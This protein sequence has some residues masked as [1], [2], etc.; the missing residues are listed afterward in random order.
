MEAQLQHP[1]DTGL[2]TG[3]GQGQVH[4][5]GEH[6]HHKKSVLKK[7]KA[8]AKKIKDTLKHGLGHDHDHD[9]HEHEHRPLQGEHEEEEDETD[10]EEMEEDAEV[11]GGPYAI[12]STD[13]R[14]EDVGPMVNLENPTSPKEDRYDH[15]KMKHEEAHRPVLQRQDEFARP[16]SVG[17]THF[18]EQRH[19]PPH[20]TKGTDHGKVE[21]Q[22]LHVHKI[23][24]QTGLENPHAS[25]FPEERHRSPF[26]ETK[27]I[28]LATAHGKQGHQGLQEH[29]NIGAPTGLEKP[30]SSRFREETHRPH[31][32]ADTHETKDI[33]YVTAHAKLEDQGLVGHKIGVP[34]GIEEDPD[35]PKNRPQLSP[36]PTN[37]QSKVTDPTGANNEA[38]GVSPLVRSFE[39]MGMND[40]PSETILKQGTEQIRPELGAGDTKF[41]QGTE[42][43]LYTGS[44]D[45]FAPW[46]APTGFP[47]VPKNTESLPKSM[48]HSK[49]EDSPQDTLTGKPGSYTEKISCATSAIADKAVAAK[50]VVAS[51]L[52]YGGTEEET[53][54]SQATTGSD[55]GTTKATTSAAEFAQKAASTVAEKL[56]PVY[57]KVAGAGTTVMAKVQ[58]TATGVTGHESRG[59]VDAGH[60]TKATD[61]GVS[62]KEYL[63]EKF[64]PG[65]EDKALSE[66][67]SGSLSRQKEKTEESKPMGKVTESEEVERRLGPIE[68]TKKEEDGASGETQVGEGFGQGVVDRLK[69]AVTTWLGKGGETQTS[70]NGTNSAVDGGAVVG[71][72]T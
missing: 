18:P 20:E 11:H 30:Y 41:D 10:D 42:H 39:R 44:H 57:E 8:K 47:A 43:S 65:E 67:I 62:M 51:K 26:A 2:H 19:R 72:G 38:A 60:E 49:P 71:R 23:G 9:Q 22:G 63:A 40:A 28:D 45:Q 64:K 31:A 16:P 32:A 68:H 24:A 17:E 46:E 29:E 70:T 54:K 36:N 61:K 69:D 55:K 59:D 14:K 15:A 27:G 25:H 34:T 6:H 33:D 35:A 56:A 66:V 3:E 12:R 21:D 37:Y 7:V 13:I 48:N 53:S 1:Q 5:E 50:N 52:G 58:G 4:D